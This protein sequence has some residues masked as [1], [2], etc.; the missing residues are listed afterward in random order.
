ME[1]AHAFADGWVAA[2]HSRD[3]DA[4]LSHYSDD[5][6]FC[7]PRV[8]ARYE[9]SGAGDASGVLTGKDDLRTYFQEALDKLEVH[10]LLCNIL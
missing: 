10:A 3:I 7:S 8:K 1:A 6:R 4:I 2:W 9:A 5:I